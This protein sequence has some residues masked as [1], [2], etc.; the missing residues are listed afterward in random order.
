MFSS[1]RNL[2]WQ[3]TEKESS[4]SKS[5]CRQW[6]APE[7][8][9]I[10]LASRERDSAIQE[11]GRWISGHAGAEEGRE[12]KKHSPALGIVG[13]QRG[14]VVEPVLA[15]LQAQLPLVGLDQVVLDV[16]SLSWR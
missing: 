12:I 9:L 2:D 6:K 13:D 4:G 5:I 8:A 14:D 3:E 16:G 10:N 7:I 1:R 15:G 11:A